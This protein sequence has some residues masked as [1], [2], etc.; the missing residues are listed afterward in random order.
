MLLLLAHKGNL[1][2]N[3]GPLFFP[4][5]GNLKCGFNKIISPRKSVEQQKRQISILWQRRKLFFQSSF[6]L[7]SVFIIPPAFHFSDINYL[8]RMVGIMCT[9]VGND[10]VPFL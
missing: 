2:G 8:A 1:F 4:I 10:R 9:D 5:K 3:E 7:H 6:L